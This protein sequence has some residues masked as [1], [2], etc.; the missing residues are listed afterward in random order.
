MNAK[1]IMS[2][3]VVTVHPDA[4]VTEI[5]KLMLARHISG[6]PVV[7]NEG[8]VLGIVSE[9]DLVRRVE[10]GTADK[11]HSWWLNF[12]A[13]PAK[14]ARD[15]V[16][17]HAAKAR[18]IMSRPAIVVEED[19]TLNFVAE[20][21]EKNHIKRVP[22]VRNGR[23]VGIVSRA[24]IVQLV[25][26]AKRMEVP[27]AANDAAIREQIVETLKKQPWATLAAWNV[28]VQGGVAELWGTYMSDEERA[29]T[30]VAIE[31]VPGVKR[32]DDHRA[33]RTAVL[34]GGY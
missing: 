30:R 4:E 12:V 29:A 8:R 25:A 1:S 26:S 6:V 20:T 16:K 19:A 23:V 24:N 15:Y 2:T 11:R 34:S 27:A 33:A 32:L 18:D 21:L 10:A 28:T 3:P 7:D 22:V 13:D 14:Q 9:G 5:A 17:S 31:G